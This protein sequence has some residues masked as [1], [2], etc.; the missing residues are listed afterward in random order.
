MQKLVATKG[1][2]KTHKNS[3][4]QCGLDHCSIYNMQ[5][6]PSNS[7]EKS[8]CSLWGKK[9]HSLQI[10]NTGNNRISCH[11]LQASLQPAC[12][13]LEVCACACARARY[14]VHTKLSLFV[15]VYETHAF[16]SVDMCM[17]L[18]ACRPVCV[19]VCVSVQE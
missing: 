8:I 18:F 16:R 2:W 10:L 19:C 1:F 12:Q 4:F 15:C 6:L 9:T 14:L 13:C 3:A 17:P 5:K 11:F 7:E